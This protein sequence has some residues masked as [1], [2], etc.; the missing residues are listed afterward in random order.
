MN[1][2]KLETVIAGLSERDAEKLALQIGRLIEKKT[3]AGVF[4]RLY[5]L[6]NILQIGKPK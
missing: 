3:G 6:Q 2:F 5:S 1:T 4:V